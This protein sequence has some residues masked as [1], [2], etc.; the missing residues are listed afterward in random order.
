MNDKP[1]V[2]QALSE[3][4]VRQL[5]NEAGSMGFELTAD[6][7]E[8]ALYASERIEHLSRCVGKPGFD[9]ALEAE[10]DNLALKVGI[11]S[12]TRADAIDARILAV[13]R[14]GLA[15]AARSLLLMGGAI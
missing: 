11:H 13:A 2:L 4:L 9:L 1:K 12:V 10:R 15:I 8:V 14:G 6:L 5:K 7:G 3:D